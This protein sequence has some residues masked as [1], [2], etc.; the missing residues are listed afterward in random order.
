M[1]KCY[2][3]VEI[4]ISIFFK[5]MLTYTLKIHVKKTKNENFVFEKKIFQLYNIYPILSSL[6]VNI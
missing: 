1:R 3:C 5:A 6:R 4:Y 2:T